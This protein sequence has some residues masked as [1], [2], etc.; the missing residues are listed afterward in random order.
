M[1]ID[2]ESILPFLIGALLIG[3]IYFNN[4]TPSVTPNGYK[5]IVPKPE[6]HLVRGPEDVKEEDNRVTIKHVDHPEDELSLRLWHDFVVL[7]RDKDGNPISPT[8]KNTDGTETPIWDIKTVRKQY[9]FDPG[10]DFGAYGGYLSG[11]KTGTDIKDLDVGLR[12]SPVRVWN[13]FAPDLLISNQAAGV[14]ISFYPAPERYGEIWSHLGVG[15]GRVITYSDD[16]NRNLFY[17]SFSTR[18]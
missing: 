1:K 5:V 11:N 14:G 12:I 18:F 8:R 17:A 15:F 9:I 4:S 16:S 2:L 3:T 6:V 13:T 7:P 10:W